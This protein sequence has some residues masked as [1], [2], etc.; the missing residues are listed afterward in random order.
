[1]ERTYLIFL[2][3]VRPWPG[4]RVVA[5]VNYSVY[6]TVVQWLLKAIIILVLAGFG[7]IGKVF[8]A[9]LL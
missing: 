4:C 1:M 7:K 5:A 6:P 9:G 8:A 3:S 2:L